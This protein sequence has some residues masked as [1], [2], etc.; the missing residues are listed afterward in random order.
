M[1]NAP[2]DSDKPNSN[3]IYTDWLYQTPRD[4]RLLMAIVY[5]ETMSG[6]IQ[7]L[8]KLPTHLHESLDV[9]HRIKGGAGQIGLRY[10]EQLSIETETLGKAHSSA[11]VSSLVNLIQSIKESIET[12]EA[13]IDNEQAA[14]VS[15]A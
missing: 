13:W 6:D 11:Y 4:V 3:N 2:F 15:V 10:I 9:I 12:V 7:K 1:F 14:L 5:V 8:D